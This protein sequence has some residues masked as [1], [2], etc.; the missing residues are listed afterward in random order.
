M[1]QCMA[2]TARGRQCRHKTTAVTPCFGV[3]LA[4]CRY[5][6][7]V[8]VIYDWS[9][10]SRTEN[11][12]ELIRRYLHFFEVVH[13]DMNFKTKMA[14]AVTAELFREVDITSVDFSDLFCL[15]F[16]R[17]M[18]HVE[19]DECPICMERKDSTM[20]LNCTHSFCFECICNWCM[21]S[22]P[23]CP[24]CREIISSKCKDETGCEI[25]EKH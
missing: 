16:E 1:H 9:K 19:P 15:Y 17:V 14:L 7:D 6:N 12:P 3:E 5:H 4:T 21:T 2:R 13:T 22:N 20:K 23:N 25:S 24:M 10:Y 11:T 8:N 18:T